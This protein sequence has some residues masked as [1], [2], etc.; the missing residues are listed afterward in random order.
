M[1]DTFMDKRQLSI[2]P[3]VP[4]PNSHAYAI[5]SV[6]IIF[7]LL[8]WTTVSARFYTRVFILRSVG[9]DD[10]TM[11]MALV[12]AAIHNGSSNHRFRLFSLH[13]H[14]SSHTSP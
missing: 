5:S 7:L 13:S 6:T 11:L 2:I 1:A 14:Q 10:W 4:I 12:R 3:L 8:T 9:W